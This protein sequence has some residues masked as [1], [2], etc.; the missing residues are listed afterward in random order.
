MNASENQLTLVERVEIIF[1]CGR[2]KPDGRPIAAA[3]V[4]RLFNQQHP[5]RSIASQTV[6][7]LVQKFKSTGSVQNKEKTRT[8]RSERDERDSSIIEEFR[9]NPHATS[10]AVARQLSISQSTVLKALHK[11]KYHPYRM[12]MLQQCHGADFV[13]RLNMCRRF[14]EEIDRNLD[15]VKNTCFSDE[16]M[17]TLD[18]Q[19]NRQN[20]RYWSQTNPEWF[21]GRRAQGS[22]K[23]NVWCGIWDNIII[24]PFFFEGNIDGEAYLTMLRDQVLP[25]MVERKRHLPEIFQQDGAPA[26]YKREVRQFLNDTFNSHWIGRGSD[27]FE[28]APRSP[29][30][31]PLDFFLWGVLKSRVYKSRPSSIEELKQRIEAEC[32]ALEQS[33]ALENVRR[34]FIERMDLCI[35][36]EGHH[37]EQL[38]V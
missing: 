37:I 21:D 26:H 16:S 12:K 4:A 24:G 9:S 30:L 20:F 35:D 25:S 28:W 3:E 2:I 17:F 29:D 34:N 18:G 32:R 1:L 8:E 19:V 33:D 22:P 13:R 38:A 5:D 6:S 10:R 7:R 36:C 11:N 23:V 27:Y 15:Y 31:T 14:K